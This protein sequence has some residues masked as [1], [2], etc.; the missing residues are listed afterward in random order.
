[1]EG[2]GNSNS[3]KEYS[4]TDQSV[5]SSSLSK[6]QYRLKQIDT[7]GSFKYSKIIEVEFGTIPTEYVLKQ[8]F[9]NPFNPATVISYAISTNS[10]VSVKV[11]DLLG[12]LITTLVSR[13]QEAGIYKV[14]FTANELSNGVY[15]YRISANGFLSTKK[16]LLLK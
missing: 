12:N 16:M 4:Y 10:F 9:P 13:N 3:P 6:Y 1:V 8:N 7:D 15:F 5:L 14:S 11:Y 2:H